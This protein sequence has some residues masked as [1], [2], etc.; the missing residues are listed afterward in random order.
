M[1]DKNYHLEHGKI[2]EPL[3]KLSDSTIR[4]LIMVKIDQC[5]LCDEPDIETHTISLRLHKGWVFCE[6]CYNTNRIHDA[7]MNYFNE[8]LHIPFKWI[9]NSRNFQQ[10]NAS[11]D[12]KK[13]SQIPDKILSFFR[14]SHKNKPNPIHTGW[15]NYCDCLLMYDR[16]L[17][18]FVIPLSFS[19]NE[20]GQHVERNVTLSNLFAHNPGLY[21]EFVESQDLMNC[22][23][24]KFQYEDLSPMLRSLVDDAYTLSQKCDQIYEH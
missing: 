4:R 24:F 6:N 5:M 11:D 10:L 17:K 1:C 8:S 21:E 13:K 16:K 3:P 20:T 7:M 18:Q 14:H 15:V 19:D 22:P 2:L 9:F 12:T 23:R